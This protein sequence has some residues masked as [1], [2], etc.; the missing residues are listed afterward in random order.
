MYLNL[1][2]VYNV[3]NFTGKKKSCLKPKSGLLFQGAT[4]TRPAE[5]GH[6]YTLYIHRVKVHW[7]Q[8]VIQTRLFFCVPYIFT[9]CLF[10]FSISVQNS[11]KS[12]FASF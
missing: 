1:E 9:Y 8:A 11:K 10:F 4:K 3:Y 6:S 12:S 5:E 2:H 7:K